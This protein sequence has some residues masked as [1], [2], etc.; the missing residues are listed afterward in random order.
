[1]SHGKGHCIL[2]ALQWFFYPTVLKALR[3]IVFTHGVWM[4]GR[5]GGGKKFVWP[6]FQKP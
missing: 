6:V 2:R 1:M 4:G 3:G 5:A